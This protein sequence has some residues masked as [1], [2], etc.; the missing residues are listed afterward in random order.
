MDK[1]PTAHGDTSIGGRVLIV[2]DNAVTRTLHRAMLATHL[3]VLTA[4][5]GAE[6]LEVCKQTTPDLVLLDLH[7][8]ELSG[9]ET[10]RRLREFSKVPVIFV[11]AEESLDEHFRAYEAG[12]CDIIVKPAQAGILVRKA[13]VAIGQ[14]RSAADLVRQNENL[15][16]MAMSFLSSLGESGALLNFM[17]DAIGC[18]THRDLAQKLFD[19]ANNLGVQ[20]TVCL[21]GGAQRTVITPHGEPTELELSI[22]AQAAQMGRIFQFRQHLVV[23]ART[24]SIMVANMPD[25]PVLAERAGKI[26]DNLA[27]L[28][29]TAD[30][31]CEN[32]DMRIES[33]RRAEQLQLA[34]AGGVAAVETLRGKYLAMRVDSRLLLQRLVDKVQS[35]LAWLGATQADEARIS[36]SLDRSVQGMLTLLEE[37]GDFEREIGKV[38]DALRG[39]D[40][41]GDIELF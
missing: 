9:V 38:L 22:L 39:P 26:R 13:I 33:M 24:V 28:A 10:C 17:R 21:N 34:L 14:H 31:L 18:R 6:A 15:Q 11:T 36:A 8:P 41:A 37:G 30:V 16:R 32:V 5:S 20:C 1:K 23:N 3:D 25:E 12:A 19:C 40:G 35:D 29:E 7:M 27:M 2:D 4:A